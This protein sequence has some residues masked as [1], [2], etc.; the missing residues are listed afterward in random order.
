MPAKCAFHCNYPFQVFI[1]TFPQGSPLMNLQSI[2]KSYLS[3]LNLPHFGDMGIH[4]I[5]IIH[6]VVSLNYICWP[7]FP[8]MRHNFFLFFF[9]FSSQ[10]NQ[11]KLKIVNG[12]VT[13]AQTQGRK[14]YRRP[15]N[16]CVD[17]HSAW[18]HM[19]IV[20][21]PRQNSRNF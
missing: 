5:V 16:I 20:A 1:N 15:M 4:S 6:F 2:P 3:I 7:E 9:F 18:L 10:R 21:Q 14:E 17:Q 8:S 19:V 13:E 12:A 11:R